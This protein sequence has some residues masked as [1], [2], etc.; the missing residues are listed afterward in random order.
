MTENHAA[1]RTDEEFQLAVLSKAFRKQN[2]LA[3][4][5]Y[6]FPH[7]FPL[8]YS[9][10]IHYDFAAAIEA[11]RFESVFEG[12][13]APRD[14]AKTTMFGVAAACYWLSHDRDEKIIIVQKESTGASSVVRQVMYE[15]ETNEKLIRDFGVFTPSTRG[16]KW[17]YEEGGVV[18][19]AQDKKNLSI[20]G[21]GVRG[22]NIGKRTTKIVVDDPH[23]PENVYTL[24]QRNKT[25]SWIMEAI[26]PTLAPK[27]SF[28]AI[29]SSYHE[30]DFLNRFKKKKISLTWTTP[31]GEVRT[32]EFRIRVYDSILDEVKKTVIWPEKNTFEQ[33][34]FRK[35][36]MGTVAF[37]RQYRNMTQTEDTSSFKRL[38]LDEM[39]DGDLTYQE[40]IK[41]RARYKSVI[42]IYDLATLEDANHANETDS[43]YYVCLTIGIRADNNHRE[44]INVWHE[45]GVPAPRVLDIIEQK[46]HAFAP[47]L[48]V[49][50]SNQFQRFLADYLLRFKNM[51]ISKSVT[52][53][54]D[55]AEL[56]LE[57]S[58]LHVAIENHLWNFPYMNE[59]DMIQTEEI[60]HEL[61]YFGKEKHDDY[62]LAMYI[63][64]KT[65]GN[66]QKIIAEALIK[67]GDEHVE[68]EN[69]EDFRVKL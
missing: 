65:V 43:D 24:F 23:D 33:L 13:L 69:F 30:D 55:R 31:E 2:F 3:Y 45:R 18:E 63:F 52:V 54:K 59:K 6:Y 28:F 20:T 46:Y 32:R 8:P 34:Q 37:N 42:Q 40:T 41:D 38:D 7:L 60:L 15:L 48:V 11:S 5:K 22:A 29:N 47:D 9:K 4:C 1:P 35:S 10:Y 39:L 14:T 51:P 27:G 49:V 44:L 21:C 61:F 56:T 50:E 67:N 26:L 58:V 16:L 68:V 25:I 62:V 17:S 12:F 53:R 57:S 66:V 19:G 36:L 64:E